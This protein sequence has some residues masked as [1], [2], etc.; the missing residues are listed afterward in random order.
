LH[1]GQIL[2]EGKP[3][4]VLT[5][6]QLTGKGFGISRYT[7]AARKAKELGIWKKESLPVTLE[8]AVEGFVPLS[9]SGRGARGEGQ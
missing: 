9:P 8:E 2:I 7:S 4:E 3:Q 6:D 1:E 5:S